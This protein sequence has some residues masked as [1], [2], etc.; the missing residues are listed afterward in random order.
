MPL[1][2]RTPVAAEHLIWL[3]ARCRGA[4]PLNYR[5]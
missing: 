5:R 1:V 3:A 2:M 4:I